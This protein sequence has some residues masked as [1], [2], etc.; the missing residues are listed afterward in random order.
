MFTD[1]FRSSVY[2]DGNVLKKFTVCRLVLPLG[3]SHAGKIFSYRF[4][5]HTL[6]LTIAPFLTLRK[7]DHKGEVHEIVTHRHENYTS[8][9]D[10]CR[11]IHEETKL[12]TTVFMSVTGDK[13]ILSRDPV[14]EEKVDQL[15]NNGRVKETK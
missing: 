2:D 6:T 5:G 10:E 9:F 1:K 12:L 13:I 15:I 8:V 4:V 7:A 14:E 11:L 3:D